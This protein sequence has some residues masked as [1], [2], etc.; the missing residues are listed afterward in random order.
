MYLLLK[1]F[2]SVVIFY[3]LEPG[4]SSLFQS[5]EAVEFWAPSGPFH[6]CSHTNQF[7]PEHILSCQTLLNAVSDNQSPPQRQRLVRHLACLLNCQQQKIYQMQCHPFHRPMPSQTPVS[8]SVPPTAQLLHQCNIFQVFLTLS[9]TSKGPF[10][11]PL[12]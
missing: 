11:N 6:L 5:C 8:M 12:E 4:S 3:W 7:L 9:P 1:A 2:F 10:L